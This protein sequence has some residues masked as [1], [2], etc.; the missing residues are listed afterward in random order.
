MSED[1]VTGIEQRAGEKSWAKPDC[2]VWPERLSRC[3]V[4]SAFVLWQGG[5]VSDERKRSLHPKRHFTGSS[6]ARQLQLRWRL[7]LAFAYMEGKGKLD[8]STSL[9]FVTTNDIIGGNSGSP[10]INREGEIVG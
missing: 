6:I 9:N 3:Y 5:G 7:A 1:N 4:H 10:V 8:L 2:G